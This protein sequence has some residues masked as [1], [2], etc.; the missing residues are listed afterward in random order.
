MA[1]ERATASATVTATL[2]NTAERDRRR[3]V[4]VLAAAIIGGAILRL[5]RLGSQ[6]FWLDEA[7]SV[8]LA[9]A[10]W[11]SFVYQ[12]RTAEANSGF[13]YVL[14]RMWA[15]LGDGDA[16]VRLLS[17]IFG[18]LTIPLAAAVARR[19][20]DDRAALV[21]AV[22]MALDPFDIWA[23]QEARGY[24]LVILLVTCSTWAFAH[25]VDAGR[26]HHP[27]GGA[28]R[29]AGRRIGWW[30][31]YVIASA[32]AVYTH[33]YAS[34]VLLA[35][36]LSLAVRPR[37]VP[38]RA[39]LAS[40]VALAVLLIPM[41]MF[42]LNGPHGN[43]DWIRGA[44]GHFLDVWNSV[45]QVLGRGGA[46]AACGYLVVCVALLA[47]GVV[48]MRRADTPHS[49][50]SYLLPFLWFVTPIA[51]PLAVSLTIKPVLDPRY[52]TICAPAVALLA[53]SV[54]GQP[55]A[56]RMRLLAVLVAAELFGDWAYF[57]RLRKENWRGVARTMVAESLPGDVAIFYAPYVRRPFDYYASHVAGPPNASPR[58]AELYPSARYSDFTL[59]TVVPL[60]L[61]GAVDS[62]R[63][64][65][66]TW[67]V[68][69]HMLRGDS[70]CVA[71]LEAGMRPALRQVRTLRF[72]GGVEV[73]VYAR[74]PGLSM[75]TLRVAPTS[76]GGACPQS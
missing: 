46:I 59:D 14:L 13:Y 60:S 24:G 37:T 72:A 25:A 6:S 29:A 39:L 1:S 8:M 7:F 70:A 48:Q 20:F 73:R 41:A 52:A 9:R 17:A 67:L 45:R 19:L 63:R 64:A 4:F 2:G 21:A 58:M 23:S 26:D 61:A 18:I 55:G 27:D 15:P 3:A 10:P 49:R 38:W 40:G 31:L 56:W 53:A 5:V 68:L 47:V 62:A 43:I 50:W 71:A 65:S 30:V 42:L 11:Q 36:W 16:H 57:E 34:F 32:L 51:I 76:L 66:R 44:Y 33:L 12:L 28:P 35:Q 69:S 75:D 22:V 54:V 74:R